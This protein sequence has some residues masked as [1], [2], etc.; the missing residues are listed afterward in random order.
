M[1][2]AQ[3]RHTVDDRR[4][5]GTRQ[6]QPSLLNETTFGRRTERAVFFKMASTFR[7][8]CVPTVEVSYLYGTLKLR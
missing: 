5:G 7:R 2:T 4:G 6:T 3:C 8:T 1:C